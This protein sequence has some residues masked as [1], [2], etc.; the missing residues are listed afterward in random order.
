MTFADLKALV[1]TTAA[2]EN[3]VVDNEDP[4]TTNVSTSVGHT[5]VDEPD[6]IPDSG[7][8]G[9]TAPPYNPNN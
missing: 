3:K 2:E 9:Q 4:Y 6:T 1:P 5:A 7:V 8:T